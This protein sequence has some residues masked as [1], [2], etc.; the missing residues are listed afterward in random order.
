[1]NL[2]PAKP[3]VMQ[4]ENTMNNLNIKIKSWNLNAFKL[5]KLLLHIFVKLW[6]NLVIS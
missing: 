3:L 4:F 5:L 2:N 6:N 1:M